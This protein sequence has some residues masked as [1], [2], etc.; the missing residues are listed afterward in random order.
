MRFIL[1][2]YTGNEVADLSVADSPAALL[3]GASLWGGCIWRIV[4]EHDSGA[5]G[6]DIAVID[7]TVSGRGYNVFTHQTVSHVTHSKSAVRMVRNVLQHYYEN[8]KLNDHADLIGVR[9]SPA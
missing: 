6:E 2:G 1:R 8:G 5:E 4:A 3:D 9:V 7:L